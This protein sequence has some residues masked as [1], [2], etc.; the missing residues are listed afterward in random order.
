VLLADVADADVA[1]AAVG[2]GD[3]D[4]PAE[5]PLQNGGEEPRVVGE[6]AV[7]VVG[8]CSL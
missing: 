2:E 8:E 5:D 4:G 7:A 3:G 1:G 6:R